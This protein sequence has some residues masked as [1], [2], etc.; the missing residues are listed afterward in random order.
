MNKNCGCSTVRPVSVINDC[1]DISGSICILAR[2]IFDCVKET[3]DAGACTVTVL[4]PEAAPLSLLT[5]RSVSQQ[6]RML[7]VQSQHY[8][9]RLRLVSADIVFEGICSYTASNTV[10]YSGQCIITV[11]YQALM[12]YPDAS[13]IKPD[14]TAIGYAEIIKSA[15]LA[16]DS[17]SCLCDGAIVAALC[18]YAPFY[19]PLTA[20]LCPVN[21]SCRTP[22]EEQEQSLFPQAR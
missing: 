10:T 21:F 1:P 13:V 22:Q 8:D 7:D 12:K 4:H 2:Q 19:V 3:L 14:L 9:S 17:F 18:S 20:R 5:A 15:Y 6:A 16:D 11:P